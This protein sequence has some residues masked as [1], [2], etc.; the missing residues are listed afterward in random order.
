VIQVLYRWVK[1]YEVTG[2]KL[3]VFPV[4]QDG[5][6]RCNKTRKIMLGV[7]SKMEINFSSGN[8]FFY[9]TQSLCTQRHHL[10]IPQGTQSGQDFLVIQAQFF[11]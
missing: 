2:L 7:I 10:E 1:I 11:G 3:M 4:V 6:W 5:I 8:V 9:A